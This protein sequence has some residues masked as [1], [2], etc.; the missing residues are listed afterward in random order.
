[1]ALPSATAT[2]SAPAAR[3]SS[4]ITGERRARALRSPLASNRVRLRQPM[5]RP[6]LVAQPAI[7]CLVVGEALRLPIPFQVLAIAVR[8]V[9]DQ[10]RTGAAVAR[11][12]MGIAAQ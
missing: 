10:C 12:D 9:G 3:S 2:S 8:D 5:R 1:M 6:V 7:G 4:S 11:F